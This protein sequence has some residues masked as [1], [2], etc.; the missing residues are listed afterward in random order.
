MIAG[1]K[2]TVVDTVI[3]TRILFIDG[4]NDETVLAGDD[5]FL[6]GEGDGVAA[7]GLAIV[8]PLHL[9]LLLELSQSQGAGEV[10]TLAEVSDQLP[11]ECG[12]VAEPGLGAGGV[13]EEG[14]LVGPAEARLSVPATARVSGAGSAALVADRAEVEVDLSDAGV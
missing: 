5:V 14:G 13:V 1:D 11:L 9:V 3:S 12:G 7:L 2:L 6:R 10:N 8:V 4:D